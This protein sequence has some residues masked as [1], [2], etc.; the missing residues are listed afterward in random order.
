MATEKPWYQRACE[1]EDEFGFPPPTN[2]MP[3]P[4]EDIRLIFQAVGRMATMIRRERGQTLAEAGAAVKF[5]AAQLE[6]AEAG[7]VDHRAGSDFAHLALSLG[8]P[9]PV[10]DKLFGTSG[11]LP[12]ALRAE[13]R[14][15]LTETDDPTPPAAHL[16]E[17]TRRLVESLSAREPALV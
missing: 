10:L 5:T 7:R 3:P 11:P 17:A 4:P 14:A 15:Y 12:E 2:K 16:A 9:R 8:V 1:Y 6:T 13:L